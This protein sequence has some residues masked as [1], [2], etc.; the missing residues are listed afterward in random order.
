MRRVTEPE[1]TAAKREGE[2]ARAKTEITPFVSG[3]AKRKLPHARPDVPETAPPL[4]KSPTPEGEQ[5]ITGMKGTSYPTPPSEEA[6]QTASEDG[7]ALPLLKEHFAPAIEQLITEMGG[8]PFTALLVGGGILP[9]AAASLGTIPADIHQK[10]D[11]PPKMNIVPGDMVH[12]GN[13]VVTPVE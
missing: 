7:E 6:P 13:E 10:E 2:T 1:K 12:E 8:N 9:E 3:Q 4:K 5:P 11:H